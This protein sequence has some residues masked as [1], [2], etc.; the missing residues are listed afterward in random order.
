MGDLKLFYCAVK[1]LPQQLPLTLGQEKSL[2]LPMY[3]PQN[4][5][6]VWQCQS[7]FLKLLTFYFISLCISHIL[8]ISWLLLIWFFYP[9]NLL[10]SFQVSIFQSIPMPLQ[11]LTWTFLHFKLSSSY[12]GHTCPVTRAVCV[13]SV[14]HSRLLALHL[15]FDNLLTTQTQYILLISFLCS[16]F[17]CCTC[18]FFFKEREKGCEPGVGGGGRER[19]LSRHPT[20]CGA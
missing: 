3:L 18:P 9:S 4:S 12:K 16:I 7:A 13:K 5:C 10:M 20:Q 6:S 14:P 1:L 19:I 15:H 2:I 17:H 8:A 11:H